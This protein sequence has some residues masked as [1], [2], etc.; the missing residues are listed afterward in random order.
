MLKKE[1]TYEDFDGN[2]VTEVLYFNLSSTELLEMETSADGGMQRMLE[3]IIETQ[4][5]RKMLEEF[6]KILLASYGKR[7]DDGKRFIKNE[8]LREEFQETGAFDALFMQMA[9]DP[10]GAAKFVAGILPKKLLDETQ[11][12]GLLTEAGVP[13][14]GIPVGTRDGEPIKPKPV[15]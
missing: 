8:Q 14:D 4:D 9:E 7:S 3:R 11:K 15:D 10:T 2:E 5:M 1:I 6:K 13:R 12:R